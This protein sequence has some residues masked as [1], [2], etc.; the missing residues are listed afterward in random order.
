MDNDYLKVFG[1]GNEIG[2]SCFLLSLNGTG[3]LLDCG[4]H[5]KKTGS[6]ALPA[7]DFFSS[8]PDVG[9][10]TH[11]HLDHIGSLPLFYRQ[12][13]FY[14]SKPT[15]AIS[16]FM[17][18]DS[19]SV[20]ERRYYED[21]ENSPEP[22]FTEKEAKKAV[23][24]IKPFNKSQ[25]LRLRGN[26]NI[27]AYP[28]GHILGARSFFIESPK[29]SVLYTGDISLFDQLT[30]PSAEIESLKPDVMIMEGTLGLESDAASRRNKEI[31]IFASELSKIL[32]ERQSV[33]CP[34]FALGKTQEILCICDKLMSEGKIPYVP[35][36][37]AGLGKRIKRIYSRFL[38][39]SFRTNSA[40][41]IDLRGNTS[42][43]KILEYGPAIFLMT[44]GMAVPGT[45]S[46]KLAKRIMQRE[47]NAIFFVGYI[48]PE[49]PAHKILNSEIGE[50]VEL[51]GKGDHAAKLNPNIKSFRITSHSDK[52]QLIELVEKIS[53]SKLILVHG[54][55]SAL[56]SLKSEFSK[57]FD[58]SKPCRGE[59]VGISN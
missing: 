9:L 58:V 45:P 57:K 6:E 22:F 13:Q 42:L 14:A 11:S 20:Q 16:R 23:K 52:T 37:L 2:A 34:T 12:I 40:V 3:I 17:L 28:A 48:D 55:E 7:V 21:P 29:L 10:I 50:I 43:D 8:Y 38:G 59:T 47:E 5:P 39:G 54:D 31:K 32:L 35:I 30:V 41:E 56:D 36:V 46:Y 4:M 19:A 24:S 33:L 44:S 25:C 49:S 1:S 51:D 18:E 15:I 53:P 26:V 27:F